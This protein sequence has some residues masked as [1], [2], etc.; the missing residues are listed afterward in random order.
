MVKGDKTMNQPRGDRRETVEDILAEMDSMVGLD[1]VKK[2]IHRFIALARLM[3][4]RRERD[5]P[6][7]R[8][9]LHMVF[10]GWPGTGKTVMARKVARMLKI[11]RLLRKG[12][13]VEVDRSHLVASYVGQTA[14]KTRDVV[15]SALDG[16]LFIDEAYTL[17]D[18]GKADPFG[19]EAVDTLLRL[20]ENHRERLV[21]I[22]A[23]Y[24]DK[25]R[26][27][28]ESNPG[29]KSRFSRFIDFPK[30]ERDEL[31]KI[32]LTL[33]ADNQMSLSDQARRV[34][35][36]HIADM[37]RDA[38]EKTFGN[39]RD[40]R[41]FFEQIV[42]TQADRLSQYSDLENLTNDEL[43]LLTEEDVRLAVESRY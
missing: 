23:G 29:L 12:H 9:N 6:A 10:S 1:N 38:D 42:T 33:V 31:E 20:M 13:C 28:S 19:Q 11:I 2:E 4:V 40:I 15:E 18:Q 7:N 16:V 14:T 36:R 8:L 27:F 3:L 26:E 41:S 39:A 25:M 43:Q 35:S 34:A 37:V 32:F 30:F 17:T 5:L 24:T 22:V 21:V